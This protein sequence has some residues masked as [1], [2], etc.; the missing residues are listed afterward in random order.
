[1]R[2]GLRAGTAPA[3]PSCSASRAQR[4]T[5]ICRST[6]RAATPTRRRTESSSVSRCLTTGRGTFLDTSLR[7]AERV[8]P[9][10][11]HVR[12]RERAIAKARPLLWRR[13]MTPRTKVAHPTLLLASMVL[14]G[15]GDSPATTDAA[16][17][18]TGGSG[19]MAGAAGIA[20]ARGAGT[21]G[22]AATGGNGLAGAQGGGAGT[23]IGGANGG[24]SAGEAGGTGNGGSIGGT[25]G[26]IGGAAGRGGVGGASGGAAGMGA[27]GGMGGGGTS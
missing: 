3:R 19:G 24:T 25:G 8:D 2:C 6:R 22:V 16:T 5:G 23:A 7:H 1:G 15:C 11:R 18:A 26:S 14:I 21:G 13:R 12:R 17:P 9:R 4:C 20:G 27:T 10:H